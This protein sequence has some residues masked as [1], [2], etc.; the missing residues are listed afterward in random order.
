MTNFKISQMQKIMF[1]ITIFANKFKAIH[2]RIIRISQ[3]PL[4]IWKRKYLLIELKIISSKIM[5]LS[6]KLKN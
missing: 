1:K 5:T 3:N 4:F 6:K 2:F